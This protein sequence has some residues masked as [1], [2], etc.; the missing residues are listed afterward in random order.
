MADNFD[1]YI[2][3]KGIN[4]E[5]LDTE[6]SG[7]KVCELITLSISP[8]QQTFTIT[9]PTD[10]GSPQLHNKYCL[11]FSKNDAEQAVITGVR[12]YVRKDT[13]SSTKSEVN[14][15]LEK[16]LPAAPYIIWEFTGVCVKS[17]DWK[18]DSSGVSEDE[19][20]CSFE[21]CLVKYRP[22]SK[23]GALGAWGTPIGWDFDEDTDKVDE[24]KD[25]EVF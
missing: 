16:N 23:T 13:G 8:G 20:T 17:F 25:G 2:K 10:S 14:T 6:F 12:I 5:C 21:T 7:K 3:F 22:Q 1:A 24:L 9:K 15:G 19:I 4:G 11:N 18:L